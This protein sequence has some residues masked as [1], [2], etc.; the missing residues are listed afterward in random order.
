MTE[1]NIKL[2]L[3]TDIAGGLDTD[4]HKSAKKSKQYLLFYSYL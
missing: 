4:K 2:D 3:K 1:Q